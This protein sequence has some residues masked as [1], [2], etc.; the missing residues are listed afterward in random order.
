MYIYIYADRT[1]CIIYNISHTIYHIFYIISTFQHRIYIHHIII[2]PEDFLKKKT[3]AKRRWNSL[4]ERTQ[5]GHR[6]Y[7]WTLPSEYPVTGV[8]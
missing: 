8:S 4:P 6:N 3:Y 7:S 2:N 1:S 5:R